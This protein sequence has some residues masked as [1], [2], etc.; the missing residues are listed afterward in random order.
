MSQVNIYTLH[1]SN[2]QV[3]MFM[4]TYM[5]MYIILYTCVHIVSFRASLLKS[6]SILMKVWV[7][8]CVYTWVLCVCLY[9]VCVHAY[10]YMCFV[11]TC[12]L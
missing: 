1:A 6:N 4:D 11:C 9:V 3:Y 7:C 12:S 8:M 10:M 5:Y 2:T